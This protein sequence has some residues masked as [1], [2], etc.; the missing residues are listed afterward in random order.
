MYWMSLKYLYYKFHHLILYGA[1]GCCASGLDFIVYSFLVQIGGQH[2]IISNC[3][4]VLVGIA[5][6][7]TLNRNY[8]FKVK[9]KIKKRF[10][11]FLIVGLC[12]M[13]LSNTILWVCIEKLLFSKLVSKVLSIVLVV[14]FQFLLN[15]YFTFSPSKK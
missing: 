14:F 11:I 10:S 6:S 4:S 13:F 8:N 2:Y 5:T 7:F 9:D 15:K 3:I 1:I 12:G